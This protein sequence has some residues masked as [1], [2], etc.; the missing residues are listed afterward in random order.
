[1]LRQ[2]VKPCPG[3]RRGRLRSRFKRPSVQRAAQSPARLE[4]G[5]P[6]ANHGYAVRRNG[7]QKRREV[8]FLPPK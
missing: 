2:G 8:R 5:T 1:M 7:S 4:A 3:L 6:N